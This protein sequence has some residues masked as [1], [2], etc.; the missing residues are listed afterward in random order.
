VT[1]G[2]AIPV[3]AQ[4]DMNWN[5]APAVAVPVYSALT[6]GSIFLPTNSASPVDGLPYDEYADDCHLTLA[7]G[8]LNF[9]IG[10]FE[11]SAPSVSVTVTIYQNDAANT[12][13]GPVLAGPYVFSGLPGGFNVVT[14]TPP[15]S[16]FISK[17]V[18]FAVQFDPPTAG[19]VNAPPPSPTL[20]SSADIFLDTGLTPPPGLVFFGGDPLAN[21]MIEIQLDSAVPV[22]ES[23]WGE[24][25]NLYR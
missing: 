19:L 18:W 4:R 3:Q 25:K 6:P 7:G 12:T 14:L 8:L 24:I 23:S 20:G 5:V 10:Y 15:D 1:D 17:D 21:F 16:P 13:L 11:Q 22:Q 9:S 2:V